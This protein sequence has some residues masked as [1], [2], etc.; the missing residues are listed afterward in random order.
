MYG[1]VA[2]LLAHRQ[3]S[4][5]EGS[6]KLLKQ[7]VA[8]FPF[9]NLYTVQKLLEESGK[10]NELYLSAKELGKKWIRALFKAYKMSKIEEQ[11]RWGEKVFTLAGM[12]KMKVA[13]WDLKKTTMIY[14][15]LDSVTAKY[16]GKVGRPVCHIPR[17][18]FAGAACVFFEKDVDAVETKCVSKGDRYCEFIIKP[19]ADFDFK[20]KPV[21]TQLK[22]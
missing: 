7:N 3:I 8:I 11:A 19:K 18:W 13:H 10:I 20:D 6:V 14:Q 9:E 21:K 22:P 12:G 16:Y 4:F 2:K 17:G 1:T 5:E 15:I